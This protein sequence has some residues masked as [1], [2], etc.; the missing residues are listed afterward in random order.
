MDRPDGW[1]DETVDDALDVLQDLVL[2][3]LVPERWDQVDRLLTRIGEAFAAA[4]ADEFRA[5]V[6]DLELSGPVRALR[7]GGTNVIGIQE[8]VLER[9]NTLVHTLNQQR[10]Q[11]SVEAGHGDQPAR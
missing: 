10:R 11:P 1:D 9:R 7:I 2:W 3:E 6:A 5:A 8:P 4:D